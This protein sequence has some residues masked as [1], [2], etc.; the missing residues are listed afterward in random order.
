[1]NGLILAWFDNFDLVVFML[2]GRCETHLMALEFMENSGSV[3]SCSD[4]STSDVCARGRIPA[5]DIEYDKGHTSS[6]TAA[7]SSRG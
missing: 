7:K 5:T 4:A 3:S 6:T 2:N 1:M